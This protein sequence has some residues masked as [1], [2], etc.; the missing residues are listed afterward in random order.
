MKWLVIVLVLTGCATEADNKL[1]MRR[2]ELRHKIFIECMELSAKSGRQSDDDVHKIVD[3][4]GS[5][6]WYMANQIIK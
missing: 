4:C 1:E 5:Q 6:S 3:A 2:G